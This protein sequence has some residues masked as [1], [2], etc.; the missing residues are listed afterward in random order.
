MSILKN[1]VHLLHS[2]LDI[3]KFQLFFGNLTIF[4]T[5]IPRRY[6]MSTFEK[7]PSPGITVF[8]DSGVFRFLQN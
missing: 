8:L 7:L 1:I 4:I 5:E 3:V 2:T 6:I